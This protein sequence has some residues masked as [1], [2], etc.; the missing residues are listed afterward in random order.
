[1]HYPL[2]V[3]HGKSDI[4]TNPNDS[5]NF[6]KHSSSTDKTIK[7]IQH[8]YHE[9]IHDAEISEYKLNILNFLES[10]Y[11]TA[12]KFGIIYIVLL[13]FKKNI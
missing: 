3:L 8:A 6:F 7:L 9:P 11:A 2:F 13:F 5:I 10:R 12:K 4:V 1:M